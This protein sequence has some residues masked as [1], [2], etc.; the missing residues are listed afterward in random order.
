MKSIIISLSLLCIGYK[1]SFST[2]TLP[3]FNEEGMVDLNFPPEFNE[4][5]RRRIAKLTLYE[6]RENL[7]YKEVVSIFDAY[8]PQIGP[9]EGWMGTPEDRVNAYSYLLDPLSRIPKKDIT[10]VYFVLYEACNDNLEIEEIENA[11]IDNINFSLEAIKKRKNEKE[12]FSLYMDALLDLMRI[13]EI[14]NQTQQKSA[15]EL[16]ARIAEGKVPILD[17]AKMIRDAKIILDVL[18]SRL[19][20]KQE[21]YFELEAKRIERRGFDRE[22]EMVSGFQMQEEDP[23]EDPAITAIM[24]AL[25]DL[26][27]RIAQEEEN[28]KELEAQEKVLA[29]KLNELEKQ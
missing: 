13:V 2:I 24:N 12:T 9:D 14:E 21:E 11:E 16:I 28:I 29:K 18:Y 8:N 1:I 7:S 17:L 10:G 22:P 20:Q 23:E 6:I 19:N 3:Y 26:E 5:L 27:Q 15:D 4:I 25:E